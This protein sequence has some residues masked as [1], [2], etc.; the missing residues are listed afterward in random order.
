MVLKYLL[1]INQTQIFWT[2]FYK[3]VG[4]V[5]ILL[6]DG[7]HTYIQQIVTAE[8]ALDNIKDGGVLA[9]EDYG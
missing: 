1:E 7:G 8:Y 2:D 5:D 6:D 4:E 3:Q 9:V